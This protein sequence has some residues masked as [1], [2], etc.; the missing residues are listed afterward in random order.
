[1]ARL[2]SGDV[3]CWVL[4][5]SR[6]PAEAAPGWSAP[7]ER[8]LD[9]CVRRS[10]RLTLIEPGQ[11]CLLWLS[12]REQPGVH[13][14]GEIADGV[15]DR[16]DGPVVHVRLCLLDVPIPGPRSSA[17]PL[18]RR[19]SAPHAGRQQPLVAVGTAVR[20]R[21]GPSRRRRPGTMGAVN[22]N[23]IRWGA[24]SWLLT[25]QF[26][27]LETLA[28]LRV[29]GPYSRV[30]D[31][32]SA[33]GASDSAGRQLMNASFVVQAGLILAGALLL[34]PA[35]LRAPPRSSRTCWGRRR[36]GS[37]SSASSPPTATRPRTRSAPSSTSWAAAWA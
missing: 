9:R 23:R 28:Q 11:P 18:V 25:L 13:A 27:V 20:R 2:S 35:L 14:L 31:V 19:R 33:L 26:F 36:S 10:Y 7:G 29:E 6:P 37:C 16:R 5:T 22:R 34:R 24:L 4:K 12:G 17:I 30:D 8:V 3:A 32:I 15:D 21:A 1:M